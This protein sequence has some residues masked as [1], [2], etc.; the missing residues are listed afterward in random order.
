MNLCKKNDLSHHHPNVLK[1][2]PSSLIEKSKNIYLC[3][4]LD[5]YD[6]QCI[7]FCDPIKNNIINEGHFIR[8]L[9]SKPFVLLNGIYLHF[10]LNI[11][12]V[13]K[14]YNKWKCNFHKNEHMD[15]M[16]KGRQMEEN[17]LKKR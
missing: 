9:Y 12:S 16:E 6:E 7:Y 17:L 4:E 13:E 3:E 8:I 1:P 11:L 5:D 15:I 10:H 2:V 14:Y